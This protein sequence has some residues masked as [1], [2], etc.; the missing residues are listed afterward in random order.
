MAT[1]DIP[2][3]IIFFPLFFQEF[4]YRAYLVLLGTVLNCM[5]WG[6]VGFFFVFV[7]FK[8]PNWIAIFSPT[9]VII[10]A[11]SWWPFF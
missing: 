3:L 11:G 7:F 6:F 1:M 4:A 5:R 8:V 9:I 10:Q 2:Q